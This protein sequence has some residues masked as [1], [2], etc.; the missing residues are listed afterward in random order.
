[1]TSP[2][3][4]TTAAR[5]VPASRPASHSRL[6]FHASPFAFHAASFLPL[7]GRAAV[8]VLLLTLATACGK[9]PSAEDA[10]ARAQREAQAKAEPILPTDRL[11]AHPADPTRPPG[12]PGVED[13][14]LPGPGFFGSSVQDCVDAVEQYPDNPRYWFQLARI[15][16]LIDTPESQTRARDSLQRAAERGHGAALAYL[17]AFES[18]PAAAKNLLL[19]SVNAGFLPA[20]DMLAQL[21]AAS[22]ID[23]SD[24][25]ASHPADSSR[26]AGVPGVTDETLSDPEKLEPALTACLEAVD[27]QPDNPRFW[28]QLGRVCYLGGMTEEANQALTRAA[29]SGHPGA[30]A[31]LALLQPDLAD[32]RAMLQA[33][34]EA[35]FAPA[36]DMLAALTLRT[37]DLKKPVLAQAIYDRDY[38]TLNQT[39]LLSLAYISNMNAIFET[40][41]PRLWDPELKADLVAPSMQAAEVEA[42]KSLQRLADALRGLAEDPQGAVS[43]MAANEAREEAFIKSAWAD[44]VLIIEEYGP[45]SPVTVQFY[46]GMKAYVRNGVKIERPTRRR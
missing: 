45:D 42:A 33:A 43:R 9:K 22:A 21:A 10:A 17:A 8:A 5:I 15:L 46:E 24:R 2:T 39:P 11:A 30:L 41:A 7:F 38:A 19:R 6:R 13:E 37:D 40:H 35:G 36:A 27:K 20:R 23:P 29:E 1:M 44:A 4:F 16:L 31:Y 12:V 34:Q 25:L 28:F 26:P 14:A 3:P 18:D 32:A